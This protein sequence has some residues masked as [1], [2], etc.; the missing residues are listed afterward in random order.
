MTDPAKPPAPKGE[1]AGPVPPPEPVKPAAAKDAAKPDA[2]AD[3]KPG[4]GAAPGGTGV[5]PAAMPAPRPAVAAS[6][7]PPVREA[8]APR[9][10]LAVLAG[11][12]VAL[13]AGG[14]G[15]LWVQ[16]L[17]LA[18]Q[19]ARQDD[20]AALREQVRTLQQRL[21]QVEQRPVPSAPAAPAVNLGPLEARVKALE[22]RPAPA[23]APAGDPALAGRVAALDQRLA[24]AEQQAAARAAKLARVQRAMAALEAGQPLGEM[25][26][27]PAALAKFA[28]TAPPGEAQLRLEFPEAARRA[29]AASRTEE[30]GIAGRVSGLFNR[31]VTVREGD[32]VLV[33]TPASVLLGEAAARVNAGDL[34]GAVTL[35][36][37]LDPGAAAAMAPWRE[38][39][40]ALVAAR[41]ALAG[42]LAD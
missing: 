30:S 21:A 34:A 42:M 33:G 9:R 15:A 8:E 12:A 19:A 37:G 5:K 16:H 7:P 40:A 6:A 28:T 38:R 35:L 11:L 27:A 24:Q 41:A 29:Q 25:P 20:V 14:I 39:A 26:G 2:K 4:P 17:E 22:E 31:L 36:E 13:L 23:A 3:A 10:R 18:G 1:G 32:K